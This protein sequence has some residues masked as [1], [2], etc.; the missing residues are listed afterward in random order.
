MT[1]VKTWKV[2]DKAWFVDGT[3]AIDGTIAFVDPNTDTVGIGGG[4]DDDRA[5]WF[6][7]GN[8][9]ATEREAQL[10]FAEWDVEHRK[11]G[12]KAAAEYLRIAEERLAALKAVGS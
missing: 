3:R 11:R 8:V 9:F 12:A 1:D 5:E 2:G 6:D 10:A 4:G 7:A